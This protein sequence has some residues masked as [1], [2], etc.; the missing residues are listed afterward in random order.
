MIHINL[1]HGLS[2]K[3]TIDALIR[4]KEDP[5]DF[6]YNPN[7]DIKRIIASNY[8]NNLIDEHTLDKALNEAA[9]KQGENDLRYL[10]PPRNEQLPYAEFLP[11]PEF[12]VY[13]IE[14]HSF[15]GEEERSIPLIPGTT[16]ESFCNK[17]RQK[18]LINNIK[19]EL[20]QVDVEK[21]IKVTHDYNDLI[22]QLE[23]DEFRNE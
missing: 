10:Q 23:I 20:R 13:A 7:S 4:L 5:E 21:L 9:L 14:N 1:M 17:Y 12:L 6:F 16:L 2:E 22:D 15:F 8:Q 3:T 19:K 18:D 11:R